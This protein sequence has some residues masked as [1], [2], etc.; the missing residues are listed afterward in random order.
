MLGIG[1]REPRKIKVVSASTNPGM[2]KTILD[3]G[4]S[5]QILLVERS[6]ASNIDQIGSITMMISLRRP[7]GPNP[8]M[9]IPTTINGIMITNIGFVI[10]VSNIAT[11]PESNV[12]SDCTRERSKY[13]SF[14]ILP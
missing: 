14:I 12:F 7:C 13:P 6:K 1:G 2:I 10:N 9:T 5:I 8:K 4:H 3:H 11:T